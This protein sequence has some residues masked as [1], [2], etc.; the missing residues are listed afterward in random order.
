MQEI[1]L[2]LSATEP[3]DLL[4]QGRVLPVLGSTEIPSLRRGTK[5]KEIGETLGNYMGS[6]ME[7]GGE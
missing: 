4:S 3:F 2:T 7:G 1:C 6:Q 5:G